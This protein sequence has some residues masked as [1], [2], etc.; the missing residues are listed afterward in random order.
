MIIKVRNCDVHC[1][2]YIIC[3]LFES[4]EINNY[5]VDFFSR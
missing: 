1:D 5:F 2:F 3:I 4:K